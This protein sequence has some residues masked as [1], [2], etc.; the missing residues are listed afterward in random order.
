MD[1]SRRG[2]YPI[3]FNCSPQKTRPIINSIPIP[4]P[5]PAEI[6]KNDGVV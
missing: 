2:K 4:Q 6:I 3:C 5:T 1:I